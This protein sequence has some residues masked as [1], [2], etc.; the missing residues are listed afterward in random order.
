METQGKHATAAKAD[1]T[2]SGHNAAT[3]R[4]TNGNSEHSARKHRIANRLM[5]LVGDYDPTPSTVQLLG[6]IA[7]HLDDAERARSQ[8]QRQRA[9][10]TARRLLAGLTKRKPQPAAAPIKLMSEF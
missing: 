7:G 10:N 5:G 6:I 3:G 1:G 8:L 9:S 2:A 4:F